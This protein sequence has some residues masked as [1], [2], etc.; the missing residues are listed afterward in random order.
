VDD[1]RPVIIEDKCINAAV[2]YGYINEGE[3]PLPNTYLDG[4]IEATLAERSQDPA[5]AFILREYV[6]PPPFADVFHGVLHYAITWWHLAHE[7]KTCGGAGM[8]IGRVSLENLACRYETV[9]DLAV[10]YIRGN[11]GLLPNSLMNYHH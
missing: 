8:R 1:G 10:T 4:Y 5:F 2:L 11:G 6:E 9:D 7:P 3:R